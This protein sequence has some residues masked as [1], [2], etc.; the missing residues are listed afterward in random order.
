VLGLWTK[1]QQWEPKRCL[2]IRIV[3]TVQ[4]N[5]RN[6][7]NYSKTRRLGRGDSSGMQDRKCAL[8]SL[9]RVRSDRVQ[10]LFDPLQLFPSSMKDASESRN[11]WTRP[12]HPPNY[13]A[14]NT[15]IRNVL[16]RPQF[17]SS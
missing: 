4:V 6:M 8:A 9:L 17:L 2:L 12:P 5:T 11:P 10:D 14:S 3:S 1:A 16:P 13:T 7:V 15:R